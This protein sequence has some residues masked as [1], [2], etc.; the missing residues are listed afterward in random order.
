[1][2]QDNRLLLYIGL[3]GALVV[4]G[5]YLF[6]PLTSRGGSNSSGITQPEF[7]AVLQQELDHC[8]ARVDGTNCRCFA[9]IS[10]N[11]LTFRAPEVPGAFQADRRELARGQATSSC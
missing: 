4:Y 1:M 5:I 3:I 11:I 9:N 7:E 10:G 2:A 6:P 8:R